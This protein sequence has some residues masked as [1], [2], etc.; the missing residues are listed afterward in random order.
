[1]AL[2]EICDM[3]QSNPLF[4][5]ANIQMDMIKY[6]NNFLNNM[7]LALP[8]FSNV[9]LITVVN[10]TFITITCFSLQ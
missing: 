3:K 6:S 5:E 10:I 4:E 9:S 2:A 8:P 7:D 1:M